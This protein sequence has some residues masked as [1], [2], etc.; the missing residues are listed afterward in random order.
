MDHHYGKTT[1]FKKEIEVLFQK[2]QYEEVINQSLA[3]LEEDN[4]DKD[5]LYYLSLS[6]IRL[7]YFEEAEKSIQQFV[8]IYPNTACAHM[9]MGVF[10][11]ETKQFDEAV[12]HLEQ[13]VSMN[14]DNAT[15]HYHLGHVLINQNKTTQRFVRYFPKASLQ[16][17]IEVRVKRAI[18]HL[19]IANDADPNNPNILLELA[20]C[21]VGLM[22]VFKSFEYYQKTYLL[23]P[24]LFDVL[25]HNNL[26]F[27]YLIHGNLHKARFHCAQ[28][29]M[30]KPNNESALNRIQE[31]KMYEGNEKKYQNSLILYWS[32]YTEYNPNHLDYL[33]KVID[34]KLSYGKEQPIKEL[35]KYL[36][37]KPEDIEKQIAY[38]KALY[39]QKKYSKAERH[40]KILQQ[41]HPENPNIK[42]WL[43]TLSNFNW[44]KKNA[45]TLQSSL[46]SIAHYSLKKLGMTCIYFI[47]A[48]LVFIKL[49]FSTYEKKQL[50]HLIRLN[51]S[52]RKQKKMK[53]ISSFESKKQMNTSF[54]VRRGKSDRSSLSFKDEIIHI[55]SKYRGKYC[56]S[57]TL[58]DNMQLAIRKKFNIPTSEDILTFFDFS[59][60]GS[61]KNGIAMSDQG[62]YFKDSFSKAV[63]MPWKQFSEITDI[64]IVNNTDYIF[65]FLLIS[66]LLG[67]R[68]EKYILQIKKYNY[69]ILSTMILPNDFED[70]IIELRNCAQ[71]WEKS[72]LTKSQVTTLSFEDEIKEICSQYQYFMRDCYF[73]NNMP[74]E[75]ISEMRDS[76]NISSP[77]QVIAIFDIK[78]YNKDLNGFAIDGSGFYFKEAINE[79][80]FIP[81]DEFKQINDFK[82]TDDTIQFN[83]YILHV[84]KY[85]ID[86]ALELMMKLR[87]CARKGFKHLKLN[88]ET[89]R[90]KEKPSN[91]HLS[92]EK[93]IE[94]VC[95]LYIYNR[96]KVY[97]NSMPVD[98]RKA[99]Y[100][101]F[102]LAENTKILVYFEFTSSSHRY[103]GVIFTPEGIHWNVVSKDFIP[104]NSLD[105][106]EMK[107]SNS[108]LQLLNGKAL[109]LEGSPISP[110]EWIKLFNTIY[111]FSKKE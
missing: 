80:R 68:V 10:C 69:F 50:I 66:D 20:K 92:I 22:D 48:I 33:L 5:G 53:P 43:D 106:K 107:I 75:I 86:Y 4:K 63:S 12:F 51:I 62:L 36:K 14:P 24:E 98:L 19:N 71:K 81:W 79:A 103:D 95:K 84:N 42:E 59:V 101:H 74:L 64:K 73:A 1:D 110:S 109:S 16:P 111:E 37:L 17:N 94:K 61:V 55:C 39:D 105:S 9:L 26:A 31:I 46:S 57:G 29:L 87:D 45:S 23:N 35:K 82:M 54:T 7:Q 34:L 13:C 38:G 85:N 21:Y 77:Y 28:A 47:Y 49:I 18:H 30:Q 56:H 70:F 78:A 102:Q 99:L 52:N 90:S 8:E 104:W 72:K 44:V 88:D 108:T 96:E 83:D 58:P 3:L 89:T 100:D 60:C 41:K 27:Y 40:F 97:V 11:N 32:I 25:D 6:Y 67:L 76:F 93:I 2:Q 15:Y 91:H 65:P